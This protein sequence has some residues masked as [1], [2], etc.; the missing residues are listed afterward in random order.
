MKCP[1]CAKEMVEE[2]FGVKVDVCEN[3]CKGIWFDQF[4]LAK[5]DHP[6]AGLGEALENALRA[7]RANDDNRKALTCPRCSIPMHAHKYQRDKEVSV[8]ECYKCGGLFLDSGEL[9][10]IRDHY[11]SDA[12]VDAYAQQLIESTPGFAEEKQN[13]KAQE[14]RTQAIRNYTKFMTVSYWRKKF[15]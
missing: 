13:L 3:G 10:E 2:N 9:T 11:M 14:Q 15:K 6:K 5:L 8:D 7:P 12:E 1:V 4:E